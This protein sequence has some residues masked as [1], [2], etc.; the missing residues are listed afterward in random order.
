[1]P[2]HRMV[3]HMLWERHQQICLASGYTRHAYSGLRFS[4][5]QRLGW[6]D[7][8]LG[9]CSPGGFEWCC[10]KF[11][12]MKG[13]RMS[14]PDSLKSCGCCSKMHNAWVRQNYTYCL[15]K[16]EQLTRYLR[17]LRPGKRSRFGPGIVPTGALLR[18]HA[19]ILAEHERIPSGL[20]ASL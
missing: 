4:W 19:L 14:L 17:V 9:L 20:P 16:L 10:S 3:F 18:M 6:H 5:E 15:T 2:Q 12:H 8:A 1:M 13:V 7:F 11:H